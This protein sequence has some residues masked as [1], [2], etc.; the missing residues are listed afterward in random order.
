[1]KKGWVRTET[2]MSGLRAKFHGDEKR[3]EN[4]NKHKQN[5]KRAKN[6]KIINA[7]G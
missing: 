7:R 3:R 6:N 5:N 2:Q 1:M 4:S